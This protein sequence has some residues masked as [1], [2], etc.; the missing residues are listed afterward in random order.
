MRQLVLAALVLLQAA[1]APTTAPQATDAA[2][3]PGNAALGR[4]Y[5]EQTCAQCHAIAAGAQT[6]PIPEAPAFQQ[7]ANTPGM[8]RIALNVWLHSPHPSMPQLI[9]DQDRVDDLAAYLETLEQR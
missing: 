8:T 6:S 4:L 9:I 3:A 1:C 5:A 2:L 7:I